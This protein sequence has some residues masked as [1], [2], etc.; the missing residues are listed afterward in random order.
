MDVIYTD[1]S[2]AFDCIDHTL[3]ISKFSSLGF[4]KLLVDLLLSYL[5]NREN[6]V[7][8]NGHKSSMF[9]SF[10]GV[11]QGSNL[12]PLLFNIF[13]NDLIS[14]LSCQ[15][16][17]YADDLKIFHKVSSDADMSLLQT[18][19]NT[20]SEWCRNNKLILNAEKCFV[21]SF[22]RK[23]SPIYGSYM[24]DDKMV[25][26]AKSVKDLGILFDETLTFN[27]HIHNIQLSAYKL[28]GFIIR[29]CRD[30][31]DLH[32]MKLLFCALVRSRLEYGNIIWYP[33]YFS[34]A[35]ALEKVQR[36]FLKYLSYRS[37]GSYPVRN[38]DY[39]LLLSQHDFKSL[40]ARREQ[41]SF[42]FIVRLLMNHTDCS[43]LLSKLN[44][45]VPCQT[46]RLNAT[47]RL[48]TPRTNILMKAPLYHGMVNFHK[49]S[50]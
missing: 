19:L 32:I 16:L 14:S 30:F 40:C 6:Y 3:L 33:L 29:T 49:S 28:L 17:A 1:F 47:F 11:P 43:S 36:R 8:Y 18:N 45:M 37:L 23:L 25:C 22:T 38:F 10:S 21:V 7:Y 34:Q 42:M 44:F 13:I 35:Y 48:P 12:G 4:S 2:R 9:I 50:N 20:I 46:S 41:S 39:E 27:Q 5:S 24:I 31:S 26:R 15:C